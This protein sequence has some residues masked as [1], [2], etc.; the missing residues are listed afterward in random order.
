M[1]W[2]SRPKVQMIAGTF[3][4]WRPHAL[5]VEG[6]HLS[7]LIWGRT[8]THPKLLRSTLYTWTPTPGDAIVLRRC[9]LPN[10]WANTEYIICPGH[11][12]RCWITKTHEPR[13]DKLT[14]QHNVCDMERAPS[15][16]SGES[17]WGSWRGP[18][19]SANSPLH[20]PLLAPD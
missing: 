5:Q 10:Y 7:I 4:Q 6:H 20:A 13:V 17:I 8:E 12:L 18:Y 2:C 15:R 16:E 3:Q 14:S 11:W 1:P 9:H 19:Q